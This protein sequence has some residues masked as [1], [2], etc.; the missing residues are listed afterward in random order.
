MNSLNEWLK[1]RLDVFELRIRAAKQKL[2]RDTYWCAGWAEGYVTAWR[3]ARRAAK[4]TIDGYD[5]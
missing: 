3:D 5:A 4:K 2:G 1:Q